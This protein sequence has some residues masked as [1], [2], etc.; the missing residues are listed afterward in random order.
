M[1]AN[2]DIN[3]SLESGEAWSL[4]EVKKALSLLRWQ[5]ERLNEQ[6]CRG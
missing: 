4:E 3:S 1:F 5:R 6:V 2:E